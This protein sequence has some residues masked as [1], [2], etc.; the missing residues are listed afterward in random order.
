[1]PRCQARYKTGDPCRREPDLGAAVCDQ[2]GGAAGQVQR[3]TAERMRLTAESMLDTLLGFVNDDAVPHGV[4]AKIAQDMLDRAGL[5]AAQVHKVIPASEDPVEAL[6]KKILEDPEGLLDPV[7][8]PP[9]LPGGEVVQ[10]EVVDHVQDAYEAWTESHEPDAELFQ[11]GP[12]GPYDHR[13]KVEN[14]NPHPAPPVPGW[15]TPDDVA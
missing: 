4:R 3:R 8:Q 9:A 7:T 10:G 5:A 14:G 13:R 15:R 11:F 2:H 12:V 1:M 6:F